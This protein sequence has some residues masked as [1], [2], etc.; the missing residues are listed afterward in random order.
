M[1]EACLASQA[2]RCNSSISVALPGRPGLFGLACAP[3]VARVLFD[4]KTSFTT[5]P[6]PPFDVIVVDILLFGARYRYRYNVQGSFS[7][8]Q[9]LGKTT[10]LRIG[11]TAAA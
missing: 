4:C 6:S 7:R 11:I 5:V 2:A 9:Q 8:L 1:Y 3:S 10:Q